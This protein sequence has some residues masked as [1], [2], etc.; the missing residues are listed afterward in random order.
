MLSS[1]DSRFLLPLVLC[2]LVAAPCPLVA[3][4]AD[5]A[6]APASD[7]TSPTS[8]APSPGQAVEGPAVRWQLGVLVGV[9]GSFSGH[10]FGG[11]EG[12]AFRDRWG[13]SGTVHGGTGNGYRSVLA[14]AGPAARLA[15]LGSVELQGWAGPGYLREE[16]DSGHVR[17]AFVAI[18][19]LGARRSLGPGAVTVRVNWVG[20]SLDAEDFVTSAPIRGF[21]IS[22]GFG[23]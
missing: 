6:W 12:A 5:P 7:R 21:R 3:Q 13:V 2:I 19:G 11:L 22:A 16:L 8:P 23:L 20:G 9:T 4:G 1:P 10:A 15:E 17:S 18:L 14:G